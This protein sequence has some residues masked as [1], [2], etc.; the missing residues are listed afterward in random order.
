MTVL[1]LRL[2]HIDILWTLNYIATARHF[3]FTRTFEHTHLLSHHVAY[4]GAPA[5]SS[6]CAGVEAE[7]MMIEVSMEGAPNSLPFYSPTTPTMAI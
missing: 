3:P 6:F 2:V 1:P 5:R 4:V 7:A